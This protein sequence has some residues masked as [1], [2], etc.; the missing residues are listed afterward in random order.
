M[1]IYIEASGTSQKSPQTHTA[2]ILHCAGPEAIE[3]F[4][5]LEF[6]EDR[7]GTTQKLFLKSLL[8]IVTQEVM[9]YYKDIDFGI[10]PFVY[11]L[12]NLSQIYA[13]RQNNAT[14]KKRKR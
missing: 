4:D 3:V 1:E 9:K 7:T 5:Q 13:F 6:N 8:S 11:L 12:T 2:I 14:F 10:D